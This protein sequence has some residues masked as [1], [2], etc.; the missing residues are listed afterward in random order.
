MQIVT[1]QT[2]QDSHFGLI[3][4]SL[5]SCT[6]LISHYKGKSCMKP[7]IFKLK[8]IFPNKKGLKQ[9]CLEHTNTEWLNRHCVNIRRLNV[10]LS[11]LYTYLIDLVSTFSNYIILLIH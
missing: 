10:L 1:M 9:D 7:N 6:L 2:H 4:L 11:I 8:L 5:P 3:E